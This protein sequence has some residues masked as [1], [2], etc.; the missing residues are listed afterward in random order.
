MNKINALMVS[1][2]VA[3]ALIFAGCEDVRV[4]NYPSGNIRIETTY[5]KDKKKGPEKES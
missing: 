4:E 3:A 2:A 1:G 5:V